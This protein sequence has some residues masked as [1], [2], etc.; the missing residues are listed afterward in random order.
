MA[1]R[2]Y[3]ATDDI[4]LKVF[5][6]SSMNGSM[7]ATGHYHFPELIDKSPVDVCHLYM[8][9]YTFDGMHAAMTEIFGFDIICPG[10][11]MFLM[12]GS[13]LHWKAWFQKKIGM[14]AT[15]NIQ[16]TPGVYGGAFFYGSAEA[17]SLFGRAGM[18]TEVLNQMKM[19]GFTFTEVDHT[20]EIFHPVT[21]SWEYKTDKYSWAQ[22][23]FMC[24]QMKRRHWLVAPSEINHGDFRAWLPPP[25]AGEAMPIDITCM[26]SALLGGGDAVEV[27]ESMGDYACGVTCAAIDIQQFPFNPFLQIQSHA[28]L[29][30]C[31]HKLGKREESKAAFEKSMSEAKRCGI[32]T[33]ELFYLRDYISSQL[34][35]GTAAASEQELSRSL[36]Q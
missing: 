5:L 30:R 27:F 12:S 25:S 6:A 29:G 3:V 34:A 23:K 32:L 10:T 11:E 8:D 7:S 16:S 14:F 36:A 35:P 18:A 15:I 20:A 17:H 33:M 31:N 1:K 24:D 26:S 9:T 28:A 22:P 19:W 4:A 13:F 21:K 2:A